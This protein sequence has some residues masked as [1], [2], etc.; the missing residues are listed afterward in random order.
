VT[1]LAAWR[2]AANSEC[3]LARSDADVLE[4]SGARRKRR[5][6]RAHSAACNP[7]DGYTQWSPV[8]PSPNPDPIKP[9]NALL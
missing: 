8:A 2:A 4:R 1:A 6:N 3:L 5:A 7:P 9:E